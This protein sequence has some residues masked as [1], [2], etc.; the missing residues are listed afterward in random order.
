MAFFIANIRGSYTK[1]IMVRT[2]RLVFGLIGTFR[3]KMKN[4]KDPRIEEVQIPRDMQKWSPSLALLAG[5]LVPGQGVVNHFAIGLTRGR[6]ETS[7]YV[8]FVTGDL[9]AEPWMP[10]G[11]AFPRAREQ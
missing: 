11:P 10:A 2:T 1:A 7:S 5:G 9:A 6:Q 3:T 4:A 8:P